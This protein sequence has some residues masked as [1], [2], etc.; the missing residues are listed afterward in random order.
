MGVK[1]FMELG[2]RVLGC[3]ELGVLVFSGLKVRVQGLVFLVWG[4]EFRVQRL[5]GLGV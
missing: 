3:L 5:R 2:Y 1:G 4:L